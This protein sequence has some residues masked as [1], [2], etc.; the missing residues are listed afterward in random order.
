MCVSRFAS[1]LCATGILLG[2]AGCSSE[3]A[4]SSTGGISLTEPPALSLPDSST[5]PDESSVPTL[6]VPDISVPEQ[7]AP[8]SSQNNAVSQDASAEP[9][10]AVP[11]VDLTPVQEEPTPPAPQPEPAPAKPT[12]PDASASDYDFSQPVPQ[13]TPVDLSYF[14]DAAF[15][16]DSR[17]EGF[18]LYGVKRGK[19][20]SSSGL[21]VFTF[22]QKKPFIVNGKSGSA[23]DALAAKEYTKIYLGFGVNELG[24]VNTEKFYQNYCRTI[25]LVRA[26]Q[27]YAVVYVQ[28]M[29]P[30]NEAQ[31]AATGGARHLNNERVRLYNDLIRKAAQEK[32][33]P[34][35]DV[36]SLLAVNDSLP[37]DASRDGVHLNREYCQKQLEYF[38]SH[39]VDFDTL[40]P[41]PK[42]EVTPDETSDL[43][44][45][46]GSADAGSGGLLPQP[47]Q[48]ALPAGGGPAIADN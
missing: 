26:C 10:S 11:T 9:K 14:S 45:A 16:G 13:R 3:P 31:V 19:N 12:P 35:L 30:V 43:P 22:T 15:I 46:D 4:A 36:Y 7:T 18:Y 40:Y 24:Y 44:A 42:P 21:S 23:L 6:F 1:L 41:Q 28:T 17:S 2:C 29:A 27:P 38:K 47:D 37:S 25:D 48:A 32:C 39:T 5:A 33:V 8:A 34:L 20:L